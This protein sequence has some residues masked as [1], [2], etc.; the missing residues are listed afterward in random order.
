M[1]CINY[2]SK[3]RTLLENFK[4]GLYHAHLKE[5]LIKKDLVDKNNVA[6]LNRVFQKEE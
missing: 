6:K 4:I 1:N 2:E 5:L 3:N